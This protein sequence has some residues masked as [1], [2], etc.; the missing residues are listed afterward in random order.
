VNISTEI[1]METITAVYSK[2]N[3]ELPFLA[4]GLGGRQIP[5]IL[6]LI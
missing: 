5:F 1:T 4:S 6:S 2:T 3:L